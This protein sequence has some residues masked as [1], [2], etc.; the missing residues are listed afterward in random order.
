MAYLNDDPARCVCRGTGEYWGISEP[1]NPEILNVFSPCM[2]DNGRLI[3]PYF[4]GLDRQLVACEKHGLGQAYTAGDEEML[5]VAG[6]LPPHDESRL[7]TAEV[8]A[9]ERVLP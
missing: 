3:D 7:P 1:G 4:P 6:I 9:C 8:S 5:I 2:G